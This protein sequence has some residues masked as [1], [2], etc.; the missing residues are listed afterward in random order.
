MKS[1]KN[2]LLSSIATLLVCFAMLIGSTYAWFTDTASTG[3]NKIQAGNLDVVLS[4]IE[5][6]N[7]TTFV[8]VSTEKLMFDDVTLWEPGAYA[9]ETFEVKNAGNLALHYQMNLESYKFNW[10]ESNGNDNYT[11]GVDKSLKD[12]LKVA[13][14]DSF[15]GTREAAAALSYSSSLDDFIYSGSLEP[16]DNNVFSV[17]IYWK[18]DT[19]TDNDY[20]LNNGKVA[21]SFTSTDGQISNATNALY[22]ETSV[23][24]NATQ[25]TSE[26]DSFG[27][28]YDIDAYLT[29][30]QSKAVLV[31]NADA[32]NKALV[33]GSYVKLA[34]DITD[35]N[36]D[37]NSGIAS[38]LDLNGK[39]LTV[40][41]ININDIREG[42]KISVVSTGGAAKVIALS[43][44]VEI[45]APNGDVNLSNVTFYK[46]SNHEYII[47][48]TTSSL[49]VIAGDVAFKNLGD[50]NSTDNATLADIT[51]PVNT[52]LVI[53]SSATF[54][55]T[56][57]T[58]VE[59]VE[60]AKD[61][62]HVF[63]GQISG[64]IDNGTNASIKI[65]TA[66]NDVVII[67]NSEEKFD[68]GDSS[69]IE[70]GENWA[71]QIGDK[72]YLDLKKAIDSTQDGDTVKLLSDVDLNGTGGSEQVN[73]LKDI[74]ID[75]NGHKL[76]G[77][78]WSGSFLSNADG[79]TTR[80]T[81]SVGTGEIYSKFRFGNG[82]A[83]MQ[84][85]AVTAWQHAIVIDGGKYLSNNVALVCQVQ[86]TSNPVGLIINDGYV[87]GT[88]DLI[89][90]VDLPGPVGGCV[91][92]VIGTV[93]I[94]GG[95]FK[96]A[97][98]GSVIIAES[99]SSNVNS[100]VNIHDGTFEGACMFDFG[101][102]HSSKSIVNVYGGNFT[103]VNPNGSGEIS[104][105]SFAY[106]NY[107]HAA[108]VNNDMFELNIMGGS[109]NYNPSAY[110][111]TDNFNVT[112]NGST[113]TVTAK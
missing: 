40:K 59:P 17:V 74:T 77:S 62:E 12:V 99:G 41:S 16:S 105:T 10:I 27:S 58:L 7:T 109:F 51:I 110:V 1:T 91:E 65:N 71:A 18:P 53:Q 56:T 35:T 42:A 108:L 100:V 8:E 78:V 11:K 3:I 107:T 84:A 104:A 39:E 49:H 97:R 73:S 67:T 70:I 86:N 106:D 36:L 29:D 50:N 113:W 55:A 48:A 69:S 88:E 103:V 111:D 82:G 80:L 25:F 89:E 4:Y 60:E 54:Q 76:S 6:K 57:V 21:T 38:Y 24:L 5:D 93:T 90:G 64:N 26:S 9:Y 61:K 34:N 75:L 19:V 45:K 28:D 20:N 68:I 33:S 47:D 23:V 52:N 95:T 102:D 37:I 79:T 22:H 94:N 14:T 13:V 112:Q 30:A 2:K 98:Y 31:T 32:L 83:M 81:D 72:K 66:L 87:G 44:N 15:D 63:S 43:G 46:D 101:D 85:N 92:A 96:A